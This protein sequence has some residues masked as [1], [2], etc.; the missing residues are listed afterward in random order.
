M[1][2]E[3]LTGLYVE[4]VGKHTWRVYSDLVVSID[5]HL[6]TVPQGFITDFASVPRLPFAYWIAG[7]RAHK[8]ATV[9]DYLYAVKL[10][11]RDAADDVFYYSML[12]EGVKKWIAKAMWAAVR[13]GG[14]S[15]YERR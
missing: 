6:L 10:V 9:H 4:N 3:Y 7:N 8:S 15:R 12:A 1:K 11:S 13:I 14:K 5:G 2:I